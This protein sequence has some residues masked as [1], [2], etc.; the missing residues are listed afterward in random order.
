[1]TMASLTM[2]PLILIPCRSLRSGKSRLAGFLSDPQRHALCRDFLDQTLHLAQHIA[3][4]ERIRL[5]SSDPEAIALAEK[6]GIASIADSEAGLNAA[7]HQAALHWRQQD[8]AF[9]A[10]TLLILPIDL[11]QADAEA[12]QTLLAL[13]GEMALAPDLAA[14]GTNALR[15]PGRMAADFR[16]QFG[17]HSFAKHQAEAAR[18]GLTLDI[19]RDDRLGFDIDSPADH[20]AWMQGRD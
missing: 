11:V 18:L 9:D 3:A 15:L 1:M 4:A 16:F 13:P 14:E 7:L 6:L 17:E 10:Q 12:L 20:T 8:T 19:L 2:A 5:V